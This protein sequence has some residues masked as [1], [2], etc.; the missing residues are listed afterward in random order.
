VKPLRVALIVVAGVVVL[1]AV[2][3]VV[4]STWSIPAPSTRVERVIPN[5]RF[6]R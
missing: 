4:L 5:E 2:A 3:A 1:L 6:S